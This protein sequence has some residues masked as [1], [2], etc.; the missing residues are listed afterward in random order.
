MTLVKVITVKMR[1]KAFS[2]VND[3]EPV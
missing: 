1:K 3:F 2:S